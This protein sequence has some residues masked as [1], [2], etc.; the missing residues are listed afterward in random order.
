LCGA[1]YLIARLDRFIAKGL[2]LVIY[3]HF[4]P[5]LCVY[6]PVLLPKL[7]QLM[8]LLIRYYP[9]LPGAG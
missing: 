2:K 8:H 1:D 7:A 5:H 9:M 3:R 4:H 6:W